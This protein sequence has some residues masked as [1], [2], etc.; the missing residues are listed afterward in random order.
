MR[1]NDKKVDP[2]A[3][4]AGVVIIFVMAIIVAVVG[5]CLY[6]AVHNWG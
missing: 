6:L 1:G 2:M 4:L 5:T 3:V